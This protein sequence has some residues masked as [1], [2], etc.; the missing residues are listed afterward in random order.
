MPTRL[1]ISAFLLV[2]AVLWGGLLVLQ[3][4]TV[5]AA[6]FRPFSAVVGALVLLLAAF[7]VFL[8]RWRWLRPWCV[9]RP[10]LNGTW[11]VILRPRPSEQ[12]G[13]TI[14]EDIEGFMV[15]RQ[16]Y[17][18]LSMRLMTAES[19]SVLLGGAIETAADGLCRVVA[20]YRNEPRLAV[21]DRSR[22][23]HGA[24]LLDI[25]AEPATGMKGHYWTDRGTGGEM[26]LT[27]QSRRRFATYAA[28]IK[29][30]PKKRSTG[31]TRSQGS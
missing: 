19:G 2:A 31:G 26:E 24:I 11:R 21:Q 28:A 13:V 29:G 9:R 1:H 6:W 25:Y 17:S 7:D 20:V 22:I 27:A 14:A 8:W 10:D 15:V 18:A 12:A 23:H 5:S 4:V 30:M 3:G 16:T